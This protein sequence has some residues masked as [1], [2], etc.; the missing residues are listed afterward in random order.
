MMLY[1]VCQMSLTV[2]KNR[3]KY[4]R[5][6]LPLIHLKEEQKLFQEFKKENLDSF[7]DNLKSES[8][9]TGRLAKEENVF[10]SL[11]TEGA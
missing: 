9:L 8:I 5:Y 6:P 11:G 2:L 7:I 10:E 4:L 3:K 1:L